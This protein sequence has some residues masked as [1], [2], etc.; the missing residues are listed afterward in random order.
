MAD[1]AGLDKNLVGEALVE[2]PGGVITNI[3]WQSYKEDPNP[4]TFSVEWIAKDLGYAAELAKAIKHPL[5]DEA[6]EQ[7]RQAI[8]KGFAQSD[9][10]KIEKL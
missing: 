10:T 8:E 6:L 9:W 1:A 4:I 2:R 7:Y 5:L 3:G